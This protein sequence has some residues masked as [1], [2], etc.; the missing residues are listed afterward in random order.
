VVQRIWWWLD[1]ASVIL[2]LR[3]GLSSPLVAQ[4]N[5]GGDPMVPSHAKM[6][7]SRMP[8]RIDLAEVSCSGRLC[9]HDPLGASCLEIADLEGICSC[10]PMFFSHRLVSE[11]V[12]QSSVSC[13]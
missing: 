3:S 10:T 11:G 7:I 1:Q 5:K 13:Q 4:L 8:V 9:R 2:K 6:K 12:L